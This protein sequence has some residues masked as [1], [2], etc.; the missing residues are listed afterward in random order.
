MSSFLAA[1][2]LRL[3]SLLSRGRSATDLV[4]TW[5]S[6]L[7]FSSAIDGLH[8]YTGFGGALVYKEELERL[9]GILRSFPTTAEQDAQLL[10]GKGGPSQGTLACM[11]S[12][13]AAG[14]PIS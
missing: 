8:G 12:L 14:Q 7:Y 9:E 5:V 10:A 13:P 2:R 11:M 1:P 6:N 3:P 4:C